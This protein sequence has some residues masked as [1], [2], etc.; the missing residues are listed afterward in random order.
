M[1][2]D[3]AS[4]AANE[5]LKMHLASNQEVMVPILLFPWATRLVYSAGSQHES[6]LGNEVGADIGHPSWS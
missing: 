6:A 4:I 1:R 5:H 3:E 2:R